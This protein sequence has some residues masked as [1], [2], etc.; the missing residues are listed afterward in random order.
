MNSG[1]S[2]RRMFLRDGL[3]KDDRL[4]SLHEKSFL[5]R[6]RRSPKKRIPRARDSPAIG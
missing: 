5:A 1:K 4:E 2:R 6:R 3:D